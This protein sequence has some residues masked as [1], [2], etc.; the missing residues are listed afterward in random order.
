MSTLY[1]QLAKEAQKREEL[2]IRQPEKTGSGLIGLKISLSGAFVLS[3]AA[4]AGAGYLFQSLNAEKRE[5]EALETSQIQFQ[6]MMHSL[7]T[8]SEQYRT[9][10]ERMREQLKTY[11]A[12]RSGMKKALDQNGL[13]IVNLQNKLKEMEVLNQRLGSEVPSS[14]VPSPEVP[15]P[16]VLTIEPVPLPIPGPAAATLPPGK[17][18][19][20]PPFV[21]ISKVMTV[22]RKF[23][24]VIVNLGLRDNIKTGDRLSVQKDGKI[25]SNLEVEKL[26]DDFSAA[27]ILEENKDAPITEGDLVLKS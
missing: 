20:V 10:M 13:E 14:E 5:R 3:L 17:A 8:E 15:T 1:E 21:K 22:N 19:V 7:Q 27:T 4:L 12:E 16:E 9:E 18:K 11:A 2:S 6:E 24:F 23:N 25:I 26:Y